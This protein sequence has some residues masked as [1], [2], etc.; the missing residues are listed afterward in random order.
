MQ[1]TLDLTLIK[2][3]QTN[4]ECWVWLVELPLEYWGLSYL[5]M[6]VVP[7]LQLLQIEPWEIKFFYIVGKVLMRYIK[8]E[9]EGFAFPHL[10]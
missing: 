2:Y 1:W 10:S 6:P 7:G 4:S 8:V 5:V 9:H 3:K